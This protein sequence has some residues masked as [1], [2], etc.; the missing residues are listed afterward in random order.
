M[1]TWELRFHEDS[2][3]NS[4]VRKEFSIHDLQ[5]HTPNVPCCFNLTVLARPIFV[6]GGCESVAGFRWPPVRE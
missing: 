3:K 4:M 1:E 2:C 6:V 5:D